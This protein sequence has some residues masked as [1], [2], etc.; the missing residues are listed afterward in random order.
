MNAANIGRILVSAVVVVGFMAVTILFLLQK[1]S[2]TA[3]G[4]VLTILVG[5]LGTNFTSVVSYWIGSSSG[6]SAKDDKLAALV[7]EAPKATP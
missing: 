4:E 3:P 7:P 2:G 6:S 5:V 1:Y